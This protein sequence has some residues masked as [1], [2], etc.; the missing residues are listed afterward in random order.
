[1]ATRSETATPDWLRPPAEQAG[2]SYY[3]EVVRE[4]WLVIA[5]AIV[6]CLAGAL[7]YLALASKSYEAEADLL[8][9]PASPNDELLTSLGVMHS[10]SDPTSDVETAAKLV[11][12]VDVADRVR[13]ELGTNRSATSLLKDVS[14]TPV[15]QS[16]IVAVTAHAASATAAAD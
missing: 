7:V 14:A 5:A 13:K 4:R 11:T 15:G 3:V 10:S 16:A 6:L 12:T 2:L 9:T 1:M 8:I